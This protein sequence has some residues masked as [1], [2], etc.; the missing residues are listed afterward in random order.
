MLRRISLILILVILVT[1]ALTG[2]GVEEEPA[3][4]AATNTA[5]SPTNT[6][7][8][9]ATNTPAPPTN[10]PAP[11][12]TNTLVVPPTNTPASEKAA[13]TATPE[14]EKEDEPAAAPK[15]SASQ[16]FSQPDINSY[17]ST[18]NVS[19]SGPAFEDESD[20][21]FVMRG[22]YTR[23]PEAQRMVI[24]MGDEGFMEMV[25]IGEKSWINFAG[26]WMETTSDET[27]DITDEMM[28][29]DMEDIGD[30][31]EFKKVG[32]ETINGFKTTHYQFEEEDLFKVLKDAQEDLATLEGLDSA[33]GDVWVT[34]DGVVVKWLMRLEGTGINEQN[35]D[36]SGA[37]EFS[38]ELYDINASDIDIQ[39]P[40]T[41]STEDTLGFTMP[42]PEGATQTM[43]MEGMITYD[44]V[45]TTVKDLTDFYKKAFAD[46]GFT[47]DADAGM[48]SA[49]FSMLT[50]SDG[51]TT[52]SV[53]IMAG[54]DGALQ[55]MVMIE[56]AE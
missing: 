6:T 18:I 43:A 3:A 45:D 10:T 14:P 53:S 4:P 30:L 17:R 19:M 22:E 29:F 39:P 21:S 13:D 35:A 44:A 48:T 2:C 37:I 31:D 34:K 56:T 42:V 26:M 20:I 33:T 38:Y 40:E 54:D 36:A 49:D 15:W 51:S 23:D 52:V 27:G 28:L 25:Q 24:D 8:P 47:E 16:L 5:V 9:A 1:S 55:I 46:L 12:A 41:G 50:F 11:A 7:A 32:S